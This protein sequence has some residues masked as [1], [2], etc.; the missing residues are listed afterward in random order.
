MRHRKKKY[1]IG[2][3][4]AHRKSLLRNLAIEIIKHGG[5]KTTIAKGKAVRPFIER[6]LTLAKEDTLS[7]RR[8]AFRRLGHRPAVQKLFE[9]GTSEE[10][11]KRPG[12]HTRIVKFADGRVGDY[13]K[14]CFISLVD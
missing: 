12:G 11:K 14:M 9:R 5:I 4:P 13:A 7:N 8:L 10:F 1:N 2:N 3:G 6:L